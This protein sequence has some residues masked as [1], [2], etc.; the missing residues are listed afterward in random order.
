MAVFYYSSYIDKATAEYFAKNRQVFEWLQRLND[1]FHCFIEFS[2]EGINGQIDFLL[3]NQNNI[4]NL[5][6]KNWQGILKGDLNAIWHVNDKS[7]GINPLKQA[8]DT[9]N[10]FKD[11][12]LN[13]NVFYTKDPEFKRKFKV[14]PIVVLP[15]AEEA[16]EIPK[17]GQGNFGQ[18][19]L[20]AEQ[21]IRVVTDLR[22]LDIAIEEG[23]VK[24]L[25]RNLKLKVYSIPELKNIIATYYTGEDTEVEEDYVTDTPVTGRRFFGRKKELEDLSNSLIKGGHVAIIGAQRTGKSSLMRELKNEGERLFKNVSTKLN[26]ILYINIDFQ[27]IGKGAT[28]EEFEKRFGNGIINSIKSDYV[29][30]G[31]PIE[32]NFSTLIEKVRFDSNLPDF[33]IK[34]LLPYIE[35]KYGFYKIVFFLDEFS[36]LFETIDY[37]AKT[38]VKEKNLVNVEL[39]RFISSLLK[40]T[41]LKGKIV[42]VL[43]LRPFSY[44][45][46]DKYDLQIFKCISIPIGLDYFDKDTTE[47]LITTPVSGKFIFTP[48]AIDE[49]YKLTAGHPWVTALFCK[50][51]ESRIDKEKKTIDIADIIKL[52]NEMTNTETV[53]QFGSYFTVLEDDFTIEENER[54]IGK[55][56]LAIISKIDSEHQTGITLDSLF[57]EFLKYKS[58]EKSLLKEVIIKMVNT[59]ILKETKDTKEV[60]QE[61]RYQIRMGILKKKYIN[62][63]LYHK[64]FR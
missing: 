48:E 32:K 49:I 26:N 39:M 25:A 58:I 55:Q 36:E 22:G 52:A 54:E 4:I 61:L 38:G 31:Q 6:V 18:V 63:N 24:S 41:D 5:E 47:K 8:T 7:M 23:M 28:L 33:L 15:K 27:G 40:H 2:W 11:Y 56:S 10:S 59:K 29:C 45:Y 14:Y 50:Q 9:A 21:M 17:R 53:F 46:H 19:V 51:L 13:T 3:I 57:E 62:Q 44:F 12:L 20:N 35:K 37:I 34:H 64:Y 43:A 60:S 30:A 42:F 1:N 16:S